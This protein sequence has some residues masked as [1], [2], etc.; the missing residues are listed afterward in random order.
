VTKP[1]VDVRKLDRMLR[2]GKPVKE[3]AKFF[4]VTPGAISQ[5]KKNLN[6]AVVKNVALENAHRVVDKNLNAVEQLQRINE[7]ANELLDKAENNPDIALKAMSEI[8]NQLKLQLD[9]FQSLYDL[10]AV[11]EFQTAVLETIA[12]VDLNVRDAIIHRLNERRAI[13]SAVNFN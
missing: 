2:S 6:I 11:Q 10:R 12:E 4:E 8:R 13:R 3:C 9:I 7:R 1:K 5:H